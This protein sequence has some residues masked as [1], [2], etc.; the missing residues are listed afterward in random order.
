VLAEGLLDGQT[1]ALIQKAINLALAGDPVALRLCVERVIAPRRDRP[2]SF[3]LPPMTCAADVVTA[4]A[5]IADG[6]ASGELTPAEAADLTK[7]TE[8]YR[9]AIVTEDFERRL[10]ALEDAR[11]GSTLMSEPSP[12]VIQFVTVDAA[13]SDESGERGSAKTLSASG[14]GFGLMNRLGR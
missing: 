4:L 3:R 2:V 12:T 7:V 14:S 9:G 5:S 6:V 10:T 1:A 11:R 13:A 8:S